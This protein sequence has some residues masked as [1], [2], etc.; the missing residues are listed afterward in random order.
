MKNEFTYYKVYW[1]EEVFEH[2]FGYSM[3]KE[4]QFYQLYEAKKFKKFLNRHNK[5]TGEI[6]KITV[7]TEVID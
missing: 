6:K 2:G 3:N 7:T 4:K 1:F 5:I